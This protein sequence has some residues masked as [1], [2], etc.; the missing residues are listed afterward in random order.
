MAISSDN[1]SRQAEGGGV[2]GSV[3]CWPSLGAGAA[4]AGLSGRVAGASGGRGLGNGTEACSA[5][6][7]GLLGLKSP[8]GA[9]QAAF[10]PWPVRGAA[11]AG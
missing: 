6:R 3:G 11:G 7:R 10:D 9:R 4:S 2:D 8:N 5:A 1:A